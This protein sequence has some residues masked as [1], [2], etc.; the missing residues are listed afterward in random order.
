MPLTLLRLPFLALKEIFQSTELS[1]LILMAMLNRRLKNAM[2]AAKY[3]VNHLRFNLE[4]H[5]LSITTDFKKVV[6]K[7]LVAGQFSEEDA[8]KYPIKIDKEMKTVATEKKRG[9]H[10][11]YVISRKRTPANRWI[12][13]EWVSR[14]LLSFVTPKTF[15]LHCGSDDINLDNL[16]VWTL[17]NRFTSVRLNM[18]RR[19]PISPKNLDFFLND[20]TADE[21][22]L[23]VWCTDE[24]YKYGGS[25]NVV[26]NIK[27][28]CINTNNWVDFHN[29]FGTLK[30]PTV[31]CRVP[32]YET[33]N[34]ILKQWINE[35]DNTLESLFF[36]VGPRY[37]R[38]AEVLRG[39]DATPT[40]STEKQL[41]RR[42]K[43]YLQD[44]VELLDIKRNTDGR[45]ATIGLHDRAVSLS[46][47]A[48]DQLEQVGNQ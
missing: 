26:P 31:E 7:A 23:G 15:S 25:N 34:Q 33:I 10:L 36:D 27:K 17:T 28:V 3:P 39:I 43:F 22:L 11:I 5:M 41:P 2:S 13:F 8:K 46:V 45:I 19:I 20:I 21:L 32:S 37:M 30:F 29:F 42:C 35:G 40:S 6:V 47:W 16:F 14:F 18:E 4:C 48:Q 38:R 1:D 12:L 9:E 44:G 24:R